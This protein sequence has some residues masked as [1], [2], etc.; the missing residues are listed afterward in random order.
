MK[1]KVQKIYYNPTTNKVFVITIE[2]K[3]YISI[4]DDKSSVEYVPKVDAA[5]G[6]ILAIQEHGVDFVGRL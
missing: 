1:Q 5:L 3:E 4:A 6:L 2:N